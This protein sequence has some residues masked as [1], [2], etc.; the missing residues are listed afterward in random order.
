MF[1]FSAVIINTI[2]HVQHK[3][4]WILENRPKYISHLAY[5]IILLQLIATLIHYLCIVALTGLASWSAFPELVLPT[6]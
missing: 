4:D 1:V 5:C 3:C 2:I 6:M